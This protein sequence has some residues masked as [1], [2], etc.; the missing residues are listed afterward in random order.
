MKLS[1]VLAYMELLDDKRLQ[2][3]FFDTTRHLDSIVHSIT[4]YPT[5]IGNFSQDIQTAADKVRRSF[6]DVENVMLDLRSTLEKMRNNMEPEMLANSYRL[7]EQEM[8]FD[9][10]DYILGRRLSID[11]ADYELLYGHLL[12]YTDWRTPGMILR[13]GTE[14]WIEHMVPMDPLYLVDNNQELLDPSIAQFTE[15]YQR[16]LRPY[17]VNDFERTSIM[18]SLP[19]GQ[20]G[21]VFAF[22]YFNYKPIEVIKRYLTEVFQKLRPGGVFMFTFNDADWA[23][24]AALAE[25]SFMCYTPGRLI[26]DTA[27][28]L[29][30]EVV[31]K[32]HGLGDIN[33]FELKKPGDI[34]SVRGGQSLAK[35]LVKP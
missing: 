24:G 22:N 15:E 7:W 19:D 25:R 18:G 30:Y 35:V 10:S 27:A 3:D 14:K 11:P 31:Y 28:I 20:F 21:L 12:G 23:H 5:Q 33:W 13:P 8:R 17:V 9:T 26:Q 16:R 32:H 29:G 2:T 4:D 1:E 34:Q 6:V